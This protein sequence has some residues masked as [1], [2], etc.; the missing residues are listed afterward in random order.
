MNSFE[1]VVDIEEISALQ[2]PFRESLLEVARQ[3]APDLV[4]K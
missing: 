3:Q 4:S 2:D 1:E